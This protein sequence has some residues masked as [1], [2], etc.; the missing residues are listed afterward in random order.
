M[1]P[2]LLCLPV[3]RRAGMGTSGRTRATNA[4]TRNA[5]GENVADW[6][7]IEA[8]L[9]YIFREVVGV[10]LYHGHGDLYLVAVP[11][12]R[13]SVPEDCHAVAHEN[14]IR[15]VKCIGD[16]RKDTIAHGEAYSISLSAIAKRLADS[17]LFD[18]PRITEGYQSSPGPVP[19]VPIGG[20]S[21]EGANDVG[22][23]E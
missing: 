12:Q 3:G 17:S 2:P 5:R 8:E 6:R 23:N 19:P 7:K 15:C 16:P 1:H 11:L 18:A 21:A 20:S 14:R 10:D 9:R 4:A 22:R 13:C